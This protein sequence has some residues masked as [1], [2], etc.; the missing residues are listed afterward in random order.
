MMYFQN[1]N[2]LEQAKLRYR[3]LAKQLHPDKGGSIVAFQQRSLIQPH[4][5][6]YRLRPTYLGVW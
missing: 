2:D 4:T 6:T 1:I 3:T 5:S